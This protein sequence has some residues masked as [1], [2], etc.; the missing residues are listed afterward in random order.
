MKQAIT[1]AFV[2]F[3]M[4]AAAQNCAPRDD[5]LNH[6]SERFGETRQS[7]GITS[8]NRVVEMFASTDS[9]TW[10]ITITTTEGATR[11]IG[12]GDNFERID[13]DP[14]PMGEEM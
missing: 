2:V 9:G 1:A 7:I 13:A 5:V 3:A 14:A 6:L 10:T 12:A 11:I 4:P 8:G